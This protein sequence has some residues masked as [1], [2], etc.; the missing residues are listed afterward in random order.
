MNPF[1]KGK[2]YFNLFKLIQDNYSGHYT[3]C[4]ENYIHNIYDHEFN[5][6]ILTFQT[7]NIN[8]DY[9]AY[10]KINNQYQYIRCILNLSSDGSSNNIQRRLYITF[11]ASYDNKS[12]N[13]LPIY[14]LSCGLNNASKNDIDISFYDWEKGYEVSSDEKFTRH[15][16]IDMN[17]FDIL[18]TSH[19]L[20]DYLI[21]NLSDKTYI[22]NGGKRVLLPSG[23]KI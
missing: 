1:S 9:Q 5:S 21:T 20:H 2:W 12:P 22:I 16:P 14:V 18:K 13:R 23:S 4:I 10:T 17:V 6:T 11:Q 7:T 8:I 15:M 3:A 19:H